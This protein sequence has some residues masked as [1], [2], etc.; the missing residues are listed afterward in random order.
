MGTNCGLL[1]L[2][3]QIEKVRSW[4]REGKTS[5]RPDLSFAADLWPAYS[6]NSRNNLKFVLEAAFINSDIQRD[7]AL[8][9]KY[10]RETALMSCGR[11]RHYD[12][13]TGRWTSKDPILFNGGDTNLYGYVANDP[14]NWVDPMG[15]ALR[16]R[17]LLSMRRR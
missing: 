7:L 4:P 3:S 2:G 16:Q 15:L 6:Q 9:L 1:N 10:V 11:S 14:V 17:K 5:T 8:D 12:P 13:E